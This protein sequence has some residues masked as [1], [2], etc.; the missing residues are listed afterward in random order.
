MRPHLP[1][2]CRQAW[3]PHLGE[4]AAPAMYQLKSQED[5]QRVWL[6]SVFISVLWSWLDS[7]SE[8]DCPLHPYVFGVSSRREKGFL[9]GPYGWKASLALP[10]FLSL[11][12]GTVI[13]LWENVLSIKYLEG[14]EPADSTPR[15]PYSP[16]LPD[17]SL[18]LNLLLSD[19]RLWPF[20][21]QGILCISIWMMPVEVNTLD[22]WDSAGGQWNELVCPASYIWT[23]G[24][25]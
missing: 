1:G 20:R 7:L 24:F 16:R 12:L 14:F 18:L 25:Y 4:G 23:L 2:F 11:L 6:V 10:G 21:E 22:V 8:S 19:T 9:P 5:G 13:L 17:Q 3:M 15:A